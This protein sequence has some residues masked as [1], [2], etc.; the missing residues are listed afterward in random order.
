MRDPHVKVLYNRRGVS[1]YALYDEAGIAG[2]HGGPTRTSTCWYAALRGD[3]SDNLPGIP[4]VGEKTAAKLVTTYGDLDGIFAHTEEQTPALRKNLTEHEDQAR[5]NVEM[6]RP[7][8]RRAARAS[9]TTQLQQGEVDPDA[10]LELFR[11]LEF[12]TLV[13]RLAEAFPARFGER[14][15]GRSCRDV[16]VLEAEVTAAETVDDGRA[17]LAELVALD[18]VVDRRG[19]GGRSRDAARSRGWRWCATAPR[20]RSLWIPAALL[21]Q[22]L[23]RARPRC[24]AASPAVVAHDA[25]PIVRS[26]LDARRRPDPPD[27]ST[28]SSPPTCW[29]RPTPS[30][31]SASCCAATPEMELADRRRR[32]RGAARLRRHHGRGVRRSPGVRRWRWPTSVDRCAPRWRRTG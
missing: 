9:T 25:K 28:R 2:A 27:R 10:V 26:L 22:L 21:G 29:I 12:P 5:I 16:P 31:A 4:K 13:P 18:T 20:P 14:C 17:A 19:M 8:A 7:G 3:P 11:F 32:P 30:T 6:M 15:R 23:D 24:C 1:D